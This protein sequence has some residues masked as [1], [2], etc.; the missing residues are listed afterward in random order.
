MGPTS[1]RYYSLSQVCYAFLED[2]PF[3]GHPLTVEV[4][5]GIHIRLYGQIVI[6]FLAS[7]WHLRGWTLQELIAPKLVIFISSNWKVIGSK[8]DLADE[9]EAA[10]GVPQS[11]LTHERAPSEFSI[12]QRMSWASR[13]KTTRLEDEAYSLMGLFDINMPTIYGE[14]QKA[15]YRLQEEIMR[16]SVDTSLFAWGIDPMYYHSPGYCLLAPSPRSFKGCGNIEF[17]LDSV[18]V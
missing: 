8:A 14:G 17:R 15:F 18:S 4:P 16:H 10:T 7:I 6:S 2:V 9:V 5:A 1:I 12:A 11:V 3:E 13:R